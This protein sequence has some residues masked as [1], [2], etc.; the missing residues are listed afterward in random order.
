M[1]NK[2]EE[3]LDIFLLIKKIYINK[4][5]FLKYF[6]ISFFI[7][8]IVALT[9]PY[10]YTSS[11]IMVLQTNKMDNFNNVSS[12]INS[13][14]ITMDNYGNDESLSPSIFPKII[15]S[16]PFN[17]DILYSDYTFSEFDEKT[18]LYDYYNQDSWRGTWMND[19][20][21]LANQAS[22]H[23]DMLQW[24]MG[25]V[26]SVF[27]FADT[28]MV[29]IE[30]EDTALAVV[31]FESGALGTIEA[32]TTIRPKDLE[33]SLSVFGEK[34]SVVIGGFAVNEIVTWN[35]KDTIKEDK[36]IINN[37]SVN[38]PNVYGYGHKA[39]YEHVIDCIKNNSSQLVDGREGRKSLLLINS[40]Y[41]SI[42]TGKEVIIGSST[43]NSKL[44]KD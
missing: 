24:V 39:Y 15:E 41:E 5:F 19:G 38:P 28:K 13:F 33:G 26:K 7:G 12:L 30:A 43:I 31:K 37:F 34:G 35:F 16:I 20:G 6:I 32:T 27:A 10:Q 36:D 17:L 22:H 2:K 23:I 14:G 21:V 3:L 18:S 1:K 4:I 44:G 25:D 40:I 9:S 29:N 11:S 42:Q 8:V